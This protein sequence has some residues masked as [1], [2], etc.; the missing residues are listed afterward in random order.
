MLSAN[1]R[2]ANAGRMQ[3]EE[4]EEEEKKKEESVVEIPA[5]GG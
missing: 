1:A 5:E 3:E 2:T 4:E